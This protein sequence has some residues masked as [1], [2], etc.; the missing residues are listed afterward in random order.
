M[1][2]R[3]TETLRQFLARGLL[4]HPPAGEQQE[5]ARLRDDHVGQRGEACEHPAGGGMGKHRDEGKPVGGKG[6]ESHHG[7]RHLHE[8]QDPFLHPRPAGG[9][10]DHQGDRLASRRRRQPDE[11]L[12]DHRA[13][14]TA[15]EAEVHDPK[16]DRASGK[17]T[18]AADERLGQAGLHLCLG[19][20]LGVGPGIKE[21]EGIGGAQLAADLAPA[22]CVGELEDALG[23]PHRVVVTAPGAD[24]ESGRQLLGR[25]RSSAGLARRLVLRGGHGRVGRPL[26]GDL[27]CDVLRHAPEARAAYSWCRPKTSVTLWPPKPKLLEAT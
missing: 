4:D 10:H 26:L 5:G 14:G 20:A 6:V 13:H 7:L 25:E 1:G 9:G 15:H 23:S 17:T 24:E 22:A 2:F 11:T 21:V 12:A 16:S 8:G 18:Q 27:D 19:K 3:Q